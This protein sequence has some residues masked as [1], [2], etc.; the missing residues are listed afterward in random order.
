MNGVN[1]GGT[2]QMD[3]A[4]SANGQITLITNNASGTSDEPSTNLDGSRVA[5]ESGANPNNNNP[6]G[7]N[8][9]YYYDRLMDTVTQVT[10]DADF[11]SNVPSMSAD[12]NII[13]F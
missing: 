13:A 4:S 2:A 8:Q 9:I 10:I 6:N 1:P 11:A 3:G 7:I 5:Y 12:G